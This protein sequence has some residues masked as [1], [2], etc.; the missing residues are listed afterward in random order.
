MEEKQCESCRHFAPA[1][2]GR[3]DKAFCGNA[4]VHYPHTQSLDGLLN[5]RTA[6]EICDRE[7]DGRFVHFELN[8]ISINHPKTV[9]EETR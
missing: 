1:P 6:R 4:A 3:F 5:I 9:K 7:G 8:R 2:G